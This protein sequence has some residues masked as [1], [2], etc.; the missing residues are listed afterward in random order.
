MLVQEKL[1]KTPLDDLNSLDFKS[2]I[3][4]RE[5]EYSV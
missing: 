4:R 5:T 1:C 3:F 2:I